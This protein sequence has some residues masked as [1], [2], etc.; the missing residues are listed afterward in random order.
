MFGA[1]S[2]SLED[3]DA[4]LLSTLLNEADRNVIRRAPA[5]GQRPRR[6]EGFSESP[7]KRLRQLTVVM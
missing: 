4:L 2:C 6:Y 3:H 5:S 1:N 7:R